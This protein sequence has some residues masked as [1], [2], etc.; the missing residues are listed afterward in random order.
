MEYREIT[1]IVCG[2]KI[3]D[4]S[5][6]HTRKFCSEYCAQANYRRRHGVGVHTVT[7]SC[8]HNKEVLCMVHKCG[9]CGWNPKVETKR[10]EALANG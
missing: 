3:V 2:K 8:I 6:C 4:R 10:K 9:T 1:C 7:P 5:S